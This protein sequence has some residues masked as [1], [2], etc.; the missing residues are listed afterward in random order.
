MNFN[1]NLNQFNF[2][3]ETCDLFLSSGRSQKNLVNELSNLGL[4]QNV[5]S[6]ML[7]N[8]LLLNRVLL[9]L[10]LYS[11]NNTDETFIREKFQKL[12]NDY[13]NHLLNYLYK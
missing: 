6:L 2:D 4:P 5:I 10:Q 8:R 12:N 9:R 3:L 7:H 1:Q 11:D 13:V